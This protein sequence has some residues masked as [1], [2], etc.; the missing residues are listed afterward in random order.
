MST[1]VIALASGDV[2]TDIKSY[3]DDA[4]EAQKLGLVLCVG[5]G[6]YA[7]SKT[8]SYAEYI[9]ILMRVLDVDVSKYTLA[10]QDLGILTKGEVIYTEYDAGIPRQDMVKYSCKALGVKPLETLE[11]IFDDV[12][13]K[14]ESEVKYINAAFEEHLT[15][16][17]GRNNEGF[18]LFG[19]DKKSNRAE[20][21][22][23]ALRTSIQRKPNRIQS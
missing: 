21:A 6:K 14:S 15:E 13:G 10:A 18:R 9:T 3:Y 17:I 12:K 16:G 23:M 8:I 2:F 11:Y 19:Y 4:L 22:T 5:S 7:P 1:Q 20:L